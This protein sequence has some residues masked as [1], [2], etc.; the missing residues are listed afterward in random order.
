[1]KVA[2]R[3]GQ[4]L[5]GNSAEPSNRVD[6]I[7]QKVLFVGEMLD[8]WREFGEYPFQNVRAGSH[9]GQQPVGG[10]DGVGDVTALLVESGGEGIQLA[11]ES[12]DLLGSPVHDVVNLVLQRF[13]VRDRSEERRVGKEC[14]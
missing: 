12:M 8:Q 10:V 9:V 14:R 6:R 11:E 3:G 13:E 4:V 2:P 7:D 5:F 1:M